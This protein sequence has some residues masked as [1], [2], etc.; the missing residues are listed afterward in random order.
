[1][2]SEMGSE[3]GSVLVIGGCG[4]LGHHIVTQLTSGTSARVS[5]L[6]LRT[7]SNRVRSVSYYDGDITSVTD[8]RSVLRQ[9]RPEI[10][11]HTASPI[12]TARNTDLFYKVNIEG[13]RNLLA[14]AS[15]V[16]SVKAFVYTS[17][18]SVVH[19]GVSDLF[20]AD[21]R[22]PVLRSPQQ[23]EIYSHT[24]G[25]AEDLVLA[26]NRK[27][28]GMLTAAIRPAG[29]FGEGDVQMLPPMLKVY[30]TGKTKFQLGNNENMFDFT[31]VGNV[32][33]A[34]ILA[35]QYLLKAHDMS[36]PPPEDQ[37]IDGEAF[38]VTND[39]P[40]RFWDFTRA[41]WRAAGDRTRPED[42]WV[43]PKPVGLV[44]ATLVE[45]IFWL[46]FWGRKEPSLTRKKIKFS[47]MNRTYSIDKIKARL[48][49]KPLVDMDEG[50]RRGVEWYE[51]E[52]I[53]RKK[54]Q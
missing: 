6:D 1:M 51:K 29:I 43:I 44:I 38:F 39:Q 2:G 48:G 23:T 53:G 41:I 45:W 34:H 20:N 5:V 21:E 33:H 14:C 42:A 15:E 40:F 8:V 10:I 17:S 27:H 25:V 16:G 12:A 52:Q 35:A 37:R 24:K 50:I 28:G 46:L 32:A 3:M 26:A 30:E 11:I 7:T 49:Y 19:D 54:T 22:L 13:T 47:C 4:F 31:Y 36:I 9:V 18:A